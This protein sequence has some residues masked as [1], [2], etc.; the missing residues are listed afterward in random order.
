[1]GPA[2]PDEEK[3][4]ERS[5]PHESLEH[6]VTARVSFEANRDVARANARGPLSGRCTRGTL[7]AVRELDHDPAWRQMSECPV[8]RAA[9]GAVPVAH[10]RSPTG[11]LNAPIRR[12]PRA[13]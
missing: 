5:G 6:P 4:L 11:R 10:G 12:D 7:P 1:M 9:V 8:R 3:A 13:R 2:E